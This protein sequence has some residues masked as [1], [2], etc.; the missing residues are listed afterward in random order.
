MEKFSICKKTSASSILGKILDPEMAHGFATVHK[1]IYSVR[2]DKRSFGFI[3]TLLITS[4]TTL[5]TL[6]KRMKTAYQKLGSLSKFVQDKSSY[7]T[8][9][10]PF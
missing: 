6:D 3:G 2:F 4:E 1:G 7:L 8:H 5:L 9:Q 10:F